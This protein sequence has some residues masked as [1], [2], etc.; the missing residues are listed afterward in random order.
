MSPPVSEGVTSHRAH[1]HH[2]PLVY[3]LVESYTTIVRLRCPTP[4]TPSAWK[5]RHNQQRPFTPQAATTRP[6]ALSSALHRAP[7]R[8]RQRAETPLSQCMG[9]EPSAEHNRTTFLET[10][11]LSRWTSADAVKRHRGTLVWWHSCCL[12]RVFPLAEKPSRRRDNS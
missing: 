6:L 7:P 1:H 9:A 3:H 11:R 5:G 10:P 8:T 12:R 4:A 2:L